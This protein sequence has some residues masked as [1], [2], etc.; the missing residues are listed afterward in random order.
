MPLNPN[1][2][3]VLN[4]AIN[5]L[6]AI[7]ALFRK[8]HAA[9]NPTAPVPTSEEIIAALHSEAVADVLKDE[10]WKAAHPVDPTKPTA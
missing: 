1:E 10:A 2:A 3:S 5:T 8:E 4:T 9:A 6:P 7:L